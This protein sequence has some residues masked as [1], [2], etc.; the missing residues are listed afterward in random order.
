MS[1]CMAHKITL[2]I[3][4]GITHLIFREGDAINC[5][6]L[7]RLRWPSLSGDFITGIVFAVF[8]VKVIRRAGCSQCC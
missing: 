5:F 4:V 7:L 2:H 3:E 8:S 6:E 1:F